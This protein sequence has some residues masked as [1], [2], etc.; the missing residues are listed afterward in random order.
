MNKEFIEVR[1][2]G[3]DIQAD[4]Y[5]KCILETEKRQIEKDYMQHL[6]KT[7]LKEYLRKQLQGVK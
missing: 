4:H 2:I 5:K 6:K 3:G 7:N 1:A